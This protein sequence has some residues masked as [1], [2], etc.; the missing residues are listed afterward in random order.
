VVD[1]LVEP[2]NQQLRFGDL[3]L[4]IIVMISCF[5]PQNQAGYCLLIVPQNRRKDDGV[6]HA[7]RFSGLLH[8]EVSRVK[9]SQS[10][11]KTDR[12]SMVGGACGTITEV[13]SSP[14]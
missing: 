2:Q 9:V 1:F 13:A 3:C 11:L 4:K 12:C 7:S 14:S 5:E 10:D 6:A 8:V